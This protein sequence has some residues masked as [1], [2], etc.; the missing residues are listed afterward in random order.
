[1]AE[2]EVKITAS[3]AVLPF[4]ASGRRFVTVMRPRIIVCIVG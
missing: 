2:A 4:V 1:M 3:E